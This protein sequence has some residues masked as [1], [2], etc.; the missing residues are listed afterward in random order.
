MVALFRPHD[1]GV[2]ERVIRDCWLR[3]GNVVD[4]GGNGI[5]DEE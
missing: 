4:G 3:G 2:V 5:G 1:A